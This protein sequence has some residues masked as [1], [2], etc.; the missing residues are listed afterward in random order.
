MTSLEEPRSR[1]VRTA[2]R[3]KQGIL[4]K[5]SGRG[6]DDSLE[7]TPPRIDS[8]HVFTEVPPFFEHSCHAARLGVGYLLAGYRLMALVHQLAPNGCDRGV[9]RAETSLLGRLVREADDT[10]IIQWFLDRYPSCMSLVPKRR[11]EC[12]V[13][14]VY[15]RAAEV[16]AND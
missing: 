13:R 11:L 12:F 7:N 8:P 1:R 10:A 14:G 6:C 9:W 4:A 3:V 2:G 16:A 5:P 15:Q